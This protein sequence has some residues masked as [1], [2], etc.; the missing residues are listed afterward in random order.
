MKR[1]LIMM[2]L[3]VVVLISGEFN[4]SKYGNA[5]YIPYKDVKFGV[6]IGRLTGVGLA[7]KYNS[8]FVMSDVD[9]ISK[10]GL[11]LGIDKFCGYG[12]DRDSLFVL[13]K[14]RE[15]NLVSMGFGC[16]KDVENRTPVVK[17]IERTDINWIRV[18]NTPFY[19]YYWRLIAFLSTLALAGLV[20]A[21]IVRM[22]NDR[23]KYH[24]SVP[25]RR[26]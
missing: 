25:L 6:K 23:F 8:F 5:L 16:E 2:S 15:N 4:A 19:I 12:L 9:Y 7:D 22:L 26:C 24:R 10:N 13:I 17:T 20:V 3:I 14:N 1:I 11:R 18:D 21:L